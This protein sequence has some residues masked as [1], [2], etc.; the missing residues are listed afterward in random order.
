MG[1]KLEDQEKALEVGCRWLSKQLGEARLRI[2]QSKISLHVDVGA[3]RRCRKSQSTSSSRTYEGEE[4][5]V[6]FDPNL[7][8]LS[9]RYS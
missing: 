6:H 3:N 4:P 7:G 8:F 2:V 5:R 9:I 1:T